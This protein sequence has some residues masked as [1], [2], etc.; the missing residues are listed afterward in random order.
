M[1]QRTITAVGRIDNDGILRMQMAKLSMFFGAWRNRQVIA[2]FEVTDNEKSETMKAYYYKYIVPTMQQALWQNGER[3]TEEDTELWLRAMSAIMKEQT[4]QNG[5]STK[6]REI[7]ELTDAEFVEHIEIIR[8][9]AAEEFGI[10]I[11][12]AK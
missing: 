5:Y 11:E 3:K 9:L 10:E 6:I 8:Q 2:R 7:E 4:W 12:D 1:K